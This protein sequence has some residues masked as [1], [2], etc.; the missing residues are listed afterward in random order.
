M[1][2]WRPAGPALGTG[3]PAE[4]WNWTALGHRSASRRLALEKTGHSSAKDQPDT[5]RPL[6]RYDRRGRPPSTTFQCQNCSQITLKIAYT[7][8]KANDDLPSPKY[9]QLTLFYPLH[10]SNFDFRGPLRRGTGRH[11]ALECRPNLS[12]GPALGTAVLTK[13][14]HWAGTGH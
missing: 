3:V 13:S 5:G 10:T 11:W 12:T 8:P 7:L 4:G 9:T 6:F 14:G 1:L 2:E